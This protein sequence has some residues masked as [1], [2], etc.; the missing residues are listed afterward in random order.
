MERLLAKIFTYS[1]RHKVKAIYFEDVSLVKMKEFRQLLRAL[2][3][4][5]EIL[6]PIM[7]R[8]TDIKSQR[9]RN[10]LTDDNDQDS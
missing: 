5:P 4:I 3:S 10:L 7:N 9:L 6:R 2:R 8:K 1:I